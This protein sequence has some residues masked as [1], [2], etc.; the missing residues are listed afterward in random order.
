MINLTRVVTSSLLA[1]PYT[2]QRST[3]KFILGG[4]K[5]E[6]V[7]IPGYGVVSVASEEDLDMMP[8]S[9]RVTGSMVFHSECRIYITQ[10]DG[11]FDQQGMGQGGFGVS[12][13]RV[14]D[15]IFWTDQLYRIMHVG[16]Y[17]NRGFWKA[18]GVRL[19]GR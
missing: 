12:K 4:W 11:G 1:E 16:P 14:S 2:I 6:S 5:T 19:S 8:E 17:P 10:L 3:G 18:I 9:D 7:N 13:Q 15:Q